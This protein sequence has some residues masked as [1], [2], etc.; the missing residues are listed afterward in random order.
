MTHLTAVALAAFGGAAI[1]ACSDR[2]AAPAEPAEVQASLDAEGVSALPAWILD[3]AEVPE[4]LRGQNNCSFAIGQ[5]TAEWNYHPDGS[6]WEHPGPDGWT[7]NQ[8][9]RVHVH[10]LAACGGGAGDVSPIRVCRLP[11]FQPN[12]CPETPTTGPLGCAICV[13]SV[14]CH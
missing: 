7:R 1:I 13:R 4:G 5:A 3:P 2:W 11:P 12:I 14:T 8:Q 9:Y 10:A 6:C